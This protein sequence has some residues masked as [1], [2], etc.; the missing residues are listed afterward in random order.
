MHWSNSAYTRQLATLI[1]SGKAP[2]RNSRRQDNTEQSPTQLHGGGYSTACALLFGQP[3]LLP[4]VESIWKKLAISE[5]MQSVFSSV[6]IV[7]MKTV[8]VMEP[9]F[10]KKIVT[11]WVS[12]ASLHYFAIK[13]TRQHPRHAQMHKYWS[14]EP[15]V[16]NSLKLCNTLHT[17]KSK[18]RAK[19]L[20]V[21]LSSS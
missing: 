3:N 18:L 20:A 9:I 8:Y 15:S 14:V 19:L 10:R 4:E 11:P 16:T 2:R 6:Y 7:S 21:F 17:F 5:S 13:A 1:C 12:R